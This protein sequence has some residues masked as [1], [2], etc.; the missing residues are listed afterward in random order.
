MVIPMEQDWFELIK[1]SAA[2]LLVIVLPLWLFLHYRLQIARAKSGLSQ[3]DIQTLQQLRDTTQQLQ[4]RVD[5]LEVLL[6]QA[7][8][9]WRKK[10]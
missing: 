9:D 6:D 1:D 5:S 2:I 8:P 4:K 7:E 3:Q 10:Q